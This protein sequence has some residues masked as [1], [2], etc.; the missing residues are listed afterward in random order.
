MEVPA[1]LLERI[2]R[3]EPP[4]VI[5]VS[6]FGGAGKSSFA[7]ALAVRI[8]APVVGLDAFILSNTVA[9]FARWEI[10]D[11]DRLEREVLRPFAAGEPVC[12]GRFDWEKNRVGDR[13]EL[14]VSGTLIVEGVG[15][16]RPGLLEYFS[17]LVWVSCPLHEAIRR[18]KQRDREEYHHPQ[19]EWWDGVWRENDEQCFHAYRPEEIAHFVV[20]NSAVAASRLPG[21]SA[22]ELPTS[23]P[24]EFGGVFP[25]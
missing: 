6:G 8:G 16:F 9:R 13:G 15:L 4:A 2:S 11:F 7:A 3:L 22:S 12:Y 1:P 23:K 17:L 25:S 20:D 5:A 24:D 19:D 10:V 18:G 14:P 21:E